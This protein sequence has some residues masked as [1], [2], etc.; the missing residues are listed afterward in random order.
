MINLGACY[1]FQER[2]DAAIEN[3]R[4][5]L[6][7]SL[8]ANLLVHANRARFNLAEAHYKR[9][10]LSQD[11]EDERLGDLYAAAVL[12]ANPSERDSFLEKAARELK[13]EVLGSGE[14]F[15]YTRLLPEEHAEHIDE[16]SEIQRHRK[17]LAIPMT[18]E[19]HA[20]ARLAIAKAYLEISIKERDAAVALIQKHGL[21]ERFTVQ[22]NDLQSAFAANA[23]RERQL[24]LAWKQATEGLLSDERRNVLLTRLME[25]ESISKSTY[26]ELCSVALAT[27]SKHLGLLA[28]RGLLVQTG[29]GPSTRYHLPH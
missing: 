27:A 5:G 13:E 25:G 24:V 2:Y 20:Q 10:Q 3:Y 6:E 29:K 26:A 1:F 8:R 17:T 18:A 9:F 4:A 7:H 21:S 23:A 15:A 16:M 22:L 12:K 28:E 11:Q 14:G 19:I